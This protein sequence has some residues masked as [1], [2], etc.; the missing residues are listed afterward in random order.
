M[1]A[2]Y[3]IQASKTVRDRNKKLS[4][5]CNLEQNKMFR[6]KLQYIFVACNKEKVLYL[7]IN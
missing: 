6:K 5:Q 2:I 3:K 1:T 7:V 4:C